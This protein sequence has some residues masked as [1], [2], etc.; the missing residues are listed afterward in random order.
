MKWAHD[1]IGEIQGVSVSTD[2]YP[3]KQC[4]LF[5]TLYAE[6]FDREEVAMLDLASA[7]RLAKALIRFIRNHPDTLIAE[8]VTK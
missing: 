4:H 7:E 2:L 1:E 6:S 3:T 5:L 8:E